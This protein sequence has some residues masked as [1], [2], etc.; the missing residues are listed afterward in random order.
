MHGGH[1][2]NGKVPVIIT[3]VISVAEHTVKQS[4]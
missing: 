1:S 2:N 4:I 3:Y